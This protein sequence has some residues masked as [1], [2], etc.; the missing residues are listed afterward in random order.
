[1]WDIGVTLRICWFA[2]HEVN[3]QPLSVLFVE[4]DL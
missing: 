4:C 3:L 2:L 1:M